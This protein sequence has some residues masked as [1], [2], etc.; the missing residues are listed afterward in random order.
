MGLIE[1]EIVAAGFRTAS[2]TAT[3]SGVP[4][5]ARLGYCATQSVAL[6]LPEGL[7]FVGIAM[8]KDLIAAGPMITA[9]A[10]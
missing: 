9:K 8:T 5:Y 7:S 2:L 10:A 6:G 4:L 1:A 3:L